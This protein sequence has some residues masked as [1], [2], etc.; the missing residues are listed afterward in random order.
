ME[1]I[2][3]VKKNANVFNEEKYTYWRI[4]T[5]LSLYNQ[6]NIVNEGHFNWE[7]MS[8]TIT[9][10]EKKKKEKNVFV[11]DVHVS[12]SSSQRCWLRNVLLA[13]NAQV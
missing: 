13:K 3:S 6:L 2:L 4:V 1:L 11:W 10:T 7:I 12:L 9:T 8:S 5:T